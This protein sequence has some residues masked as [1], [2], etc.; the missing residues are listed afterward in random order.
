MKYEMEFGEFLTTHKRSSRTG[1]LFSLRVG[2]DVV[3]R[4]RVVEREL[5]VELSRVNVGHVVGL[6]EVLKTIR[7]RK[8]SSTTA[9]PYAHN[10][11]IYSV[12]IYCEF[13]RFKKTL[14]S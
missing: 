9:R 6:T 2:R 7:E 12:K 3:T 4:C 10:D 13:L 1:E 11:L 5:S 8:L 14:S